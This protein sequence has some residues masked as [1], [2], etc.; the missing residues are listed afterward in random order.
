MLVNFSICVRKQRKDG[1]WPVYIRMTL[2]R[3]VA[4]LKTNKLVSSCDTDRG[5]HITDR[6]VIKHCQDQIDSYCQVLNQVDLTGRSVNEIRDLLK[7]PL[8]MSASFTE[9]ARKFIYDEIAVHSEG[10]ARLYLAA[11][12]S[13]AK[14]FAHEDIKF[15][16]VTVRQIKFWLNKLDDTK[17]ARESYPICLRQ[18]W[19]K[20]RKMFAEMYDDTSINPLPDV[21]ANIEI[22]DSELATRQP[23]S[24]EE[25]RV[26]FSAPIPVNQKGNAL[27]KLGRDVAM[28]VL[29]LAGINTVDLFYMR[30]SNVRNGRLCYNRTKTSRRRFDKAYIEITIPEVLKPIVEEYVAGEDSEHY[31]VFSKMYASAKSFNI[32]VNAGLKQMCRSIAGLDRIYT[33]YQFRHTWATTAQND[34]GASF[35]EIG[36]ALNHLDGNRVTRGY[37]KP[38]FSKIWELNERVID[39][40]LFSDLA[41]KRAKKE[42]PTEEVT[43]EVTP[44][45]LIRAAAFYQGR[46]LANFEDLGYTEIDGVTRKLVSRFPNDIPE[47]GIVQFKIVNIDTGKVRVYQL[48]KG[49]GF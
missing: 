40:I 35:S 42:K 44:G 18:I 39:F 14:T 9:F 33:S 27:A 38:D 47:G 32:S 24:A 49:A 7:V 21:W 23:L 20:A 46:C 31:F 28:M 34:C 45:V 2:G 19:K 26:F 11:L 30:K 43:F 36:F 4:Y 8:E 5:G 12:N 41:S 10:N 13:F 1:L 29:C 6:F 3:K 15:S 37:V 22:H 25:C 17:R 16:D 48:Q